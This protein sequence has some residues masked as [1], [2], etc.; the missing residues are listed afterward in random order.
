MSLKYI[1]WL[2]DVSFPGM[3]FTVDYSYM[4]PY[5]QV[6]IRAGGRIES[7]HYANAVVWAEMAFVPPHD[8]E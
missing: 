1:E 5:L 8:Q 4:P 2:K 6:P 7:L 3:A